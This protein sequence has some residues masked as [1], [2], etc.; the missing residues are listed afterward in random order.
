MSVAAPA[1]TPILASPQ[2]QP[3]AEANGPVHTEGVRMLAVERSAGQLVLGIL[4][5]LPVLLRKMLAVAT[6]V[7]GCPVAAAGDNHLQAYGSGLA[8]LPDP[9]RGCTD[10]KHPFGT[11]G[12]G[13]ISWAICCRTT[14]L[15]LI[16]IA[17][18][19]SQFHPE[20]MR[21]RH[22]LTSGA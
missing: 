16:G 22:C 2:V 20:V 11:L 1:E 8:A 19:R 14:R 7:D 18:D 3:L 5:V 9:A 13:L 21:I 17:H 15:R 10:P 4:V 6:G 12:D